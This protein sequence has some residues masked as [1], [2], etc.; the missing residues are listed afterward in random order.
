MGSSGLRRLSAHDRVWL[1]LEVAALGTL[2]LGIG[3]WSHLAPYA[4]TN[5]ASPWLRAAS[6]LPWA[7][8]LLA[9]LGTELASRAR[10]GLVPGLRSAVRRGLPLV[11]LW[12]AP[13]LLSRRAF[14]EQPLFLM[15]L[16]GAATLGLEACLRRADAGAW[17]A[18]VSEP[19]GSRVLPRLLAGAAI[20]ACVTFLYLS[21]VRLHDKFAT[22]NYD[23][24]LFENLFWNSMHGR[25]G[26]ALD[27]PYFAQHAEF[28]VYALLPFYAAFPHTETLFA[29]QAALMA[30]A[31]VPLFLLAERWLG[32]AWAGL[33]LVLAY[34][35]HPAIHGPAL[36]D[37]HFLPLS[38]FFLLWAAY[39]HARRPG[40]IPF[41]L[42]LVL[43]LC[44]REDV[45]IGV[46][47]VGLGLAW[48][49]RRAS[50]SSAYG[51]VRRVGWCMAGL[52]LAWFILVKFVWMRQ[53]GPGSFAAYY[54]ELIPQGSRGFGSVLLTLVS[55][56]VYTLS[57]LLTLE[58][59]LLALQFLVPLAFL[60]VRYARASFLLLPG[61]IVVGLADSGSTITTVHLHYATHFLPYVFI[62]AVGA[63]AVRARGWRAP[64]LLA[65][66]FGSLVSTLHFGAFF[67]DAYKTSFHDLEFEWGQ[68]DIEREQAFQRLAA[69][70]PDD[71]SVSAGEYEGP[72]VARRG[73]LISLKAGCQGADYVIYSRR[74]L[75]WGGGR[76]VEEALRNGSYGL[77]GIGADMALL[78][79]DYDP[80]RNAEGLRH[81]LGK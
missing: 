9:L 42:A 78:A 67:V 13:L 12:V 25:P 43:A 60:P 47:A 51:R 22:S 31:A 56:P 14:N 30:G 26:I 7:V 2:L 3:A 55:N 73:T 36:Y 75:H 20:A 16:T 62:A 76:D 45:A 53:F 33:A 38:A 34:L 59:C 44:C 65:L 61:L 64:A 18:R 27:L 63:L 8:A 66:L 41:W 5:A 71:A 1:F 23:L 15:L 37:F 4:E 70:I 49:A 81:L 79:R 54:S 21:G 48:N 24:G 58:K 57:R 6:V 52:G 11:A 32:S 40:S 29:L 68:A 69:Q 80:A 72:H 74:S 50:A 28:L 19:L 39:F 17:L 77:V 35:S 10:P 46:L